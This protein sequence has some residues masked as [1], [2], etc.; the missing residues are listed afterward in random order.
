MR[1]DFHGS[2]LRL[3]SA[4]RR[5]PQPRFFRREL[6]VELALEVLD[7]VALFDDDDTTYKR[8]NP[9]EHASV[10]NIVDSCVSP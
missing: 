5:R 10:S 9:Y 3:H 4:T 2:F 6:G 7:V 1:V 8:Y